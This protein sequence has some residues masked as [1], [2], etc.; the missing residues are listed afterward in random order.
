DLRNRAVTEAGREVDPIRRVER[1]VDAAAVEEGVDQA[2]A[3][4]RLVRPEIIGVTETSQ[5]DLVAVRQ[6]RE[7]LTRS[8]LRRR[9]EVEAAADQKRLDVR[10][11]DAGVLVLVRA[12]RPRVEQTAAG[13]DQLGTGAADHRPVVG[14]ACEE[15]PGVASVV[16]ADRG[17]IAPN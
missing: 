4:P 5:Y 2:L 6:M 11:L 12:R 13:P 17:D 16:P 1:P 3:R 10:V 8:V 9:R 15:A 14:M 7:Q